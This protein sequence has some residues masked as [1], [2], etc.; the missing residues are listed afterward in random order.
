MHRAYL[1]ETGHTPRASISSSR[2]QRFSLG[3]NTLTKINRE[4]VKC[5]WRHRRH[6]PGNFVVLGGQV[7]F[8][9]GSLIN[10]TGVLDLKADG[11]VTLD[12]TSIR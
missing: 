6:G 7:T 2:A 11:T 12:E 8:N 4:T 3:G 5:Q 9:D 10:G 1:A